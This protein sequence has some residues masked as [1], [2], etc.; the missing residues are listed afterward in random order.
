[1]ARQQK[2]Y[3]FYPNKTDDET[4]TKTKIKIGTKNILLATYEKERRINIY[5]G[6]HDKWCI[7][8]ELIKD[9]G[10]V[11][12]LGY[13]IQ[14]R[15]DLLC[16]LDDNF[17]RGHDIK[18]LIRFLIQHIY[19]NYPMVKGLS[20]NDLSTKQ[21]NNEIDVNL[22][23]MTYL[24]SGKTWY[25]KNFDVI[26]SP[27]SIDNWNKNIEKLTNAK[28]LQWDEISN[29]IRLETLLSLTKSKDDTLLFQNE[30]DV[31]ILYDESKT[32]QDFFGEIN[33]QI[34]IADFCDFISN[35]IVKFIA[36]YFSNLYDLTFI[37]QI[38][39][40]DISYNQSEYQRGGKRFTRKATRKVFKDYK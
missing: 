36:H 17:T 23:V 18:Q 38:K 14:I 11:K 28:Q 34:E 15:Y 30:D 19:N 39:D 29:T 9:N 22:A 8:C 20:F 21:C 12:E 7:Y 33:K 10:I 2:R 35:W 32:W 40:L 4:L 31:K 3:G 26:V 13:L 16:S 25:Q 27:Q 5:V 6:G 1:M 37:L 24:Y